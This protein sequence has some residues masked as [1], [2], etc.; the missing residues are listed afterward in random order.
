MNPNSKQA[1][2][3]FYEELN[4]FLAKNKR[5]VAFIF[6]FIG[7]PKIKNVIEMIGVPHSEIDLI[8]VNGEPVDFNYRLLAGDNVSIYPIF[9][10]IDIT[11]INRLRPTPLRETKFILDVH[12]GRLAKYLRICGFDCCYEDLEDK[13]IVVT[14]V[15]QKR[16]IL[17][18]DRCLLKN[19]AVTH[20]YWVRSRE[21][22]QQVVEV[23]ERFD[24]IDKIRFLTRCLLC[25][26]KLK[27]ISKSKADEKVPAKAS[28]YY[29]DF[30][31]CPFCNKVY[32]EGSHYKNMLQ[33]VEFVRSSL[34]NRSAPKRSK[35]KR[36]DLN[37][38][39]A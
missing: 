14:S 29:E 15:R 39:F 12:L 22:H 30:Y 33:L 7:A 16:I 18:K 37:E 5:K 32:W 1:T 20:G 9:E 23:F 19:K 31:L 11:P 13:E 35:H 6:S 2:F 27:T 3:R 21:P 34:G 10:A 8:L 17:T 4:D 28:Q 26:T 38:K 24:L 25:N 36:P